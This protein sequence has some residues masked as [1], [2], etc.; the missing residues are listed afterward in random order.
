MLCHLLEKINFCYNKSECH[1][2]V[3]GVCHNKSISRFNYEK[4][5]DSKTD[6]AYALALARRGCPQSDIQKRLLTERTHWKN[7]EGIRRKN[8][9][10]LRT[11][12]K[13]VDIVRN[14]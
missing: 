10:I 2:L 8:S 11:I 14:S 9:Y 1:C 13:A 5:D 7:H 12:E 3:G 6:F 4:N